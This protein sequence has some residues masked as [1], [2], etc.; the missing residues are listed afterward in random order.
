MMN[1]NEARMAA[2][3]VTVGRNKIQLDEIEKLIHNAV[4]QGKT[5]IYL[6]EYLFPA[7]QSYLKELGYVIQQSSHMNE[8]TVTINW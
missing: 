8:V 4:D 6:Y 1:A 2:E 5:T 3:N 7:N